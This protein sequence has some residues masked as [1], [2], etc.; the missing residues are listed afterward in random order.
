[1]GVVDLLGGWLEDIE[2]STS[3]TPLDAW[4]WN[5]EGDEKVVWVGGGEGVDIE[6]VGTVDKLPEVVYGVRSSTSG[7]STRMVFFA[8]K[9][10]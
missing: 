3:L 10:P 2:L 8:A 7:K 9:L 4:N 5:G 6:L 1:M